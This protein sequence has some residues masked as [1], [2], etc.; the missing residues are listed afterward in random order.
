MQR[1]RKRSRRAQIN[2]DRFGRIALLAVVAGIA[3]L[4][5]SPLQGLLGAAD[6]A[7]KRKSQLADLTAEN[8][9]L[10]KRERDLRDPVAIETAAREM[11]MVLPEETAIAVR[12]KVLVA[13]DPNTDSDEEFTSDQSSGNN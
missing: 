13:E 4:Y 9:R 2:W 12:G 7:N 11:G 5:V 1:K 10:T 6:E 8:K 3:F